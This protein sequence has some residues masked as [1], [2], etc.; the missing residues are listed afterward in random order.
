MSG[1]EDQKINQTN[2]KN[3]IQTESV[4]EGWKEAVKPTRQKRYTLEL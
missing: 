2:E 4:M 3:I 1:Y